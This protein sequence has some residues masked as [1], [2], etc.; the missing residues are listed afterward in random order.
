MA[1]DDKNAVPT[2][3]VYAYAFGSHAC[4][5]KRATLRAIPT[6]MKAKEAYNGLYNSNSC[7]LIDIS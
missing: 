7:I 4:N 5:G 2:E 1:V 6:V 3:G